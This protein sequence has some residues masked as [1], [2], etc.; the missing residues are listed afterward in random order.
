MEIHQYIGAGL[1]IPGVLFMLLAAVGV[2]RMPDTLMRM[3]AASKAGT[4]GV[5]LIAIGAAT[6]LGTMFAA[7][8][9]LLLIVL[10]MLTAPVASH[11]I[12][13]A[14]YRRGGGLYHRTV[15]PKSDEEVDDDR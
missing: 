8:A 15:L 11:L 5:A 2:L 9:A 7:G 14:A 3:Q 1:V 6:W 10:F 12:G 13:R 4:L